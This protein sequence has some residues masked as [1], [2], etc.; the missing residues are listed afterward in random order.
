MTVDD[1]PTVTYGIDDLDYH[2]EITRRLLDVFDQYLIP[3]IGFVNER[4][5]YWENALDT[6]R[7]RLLEEW[8]Q[9]G[10]EL[11][12]HTYAHTNYHQVPLRVYAEDIQKGERVTRPLME[13]YGYELRYFRHPYLRIGLTKAHHDSLRQFLQQQQ[14]QEAPVTI[15]NDDYLFAKAYHHAFVRQDSSLMRQIGHD[16]VAY[17]EEKVHYFERASEQLEGRNVKHIL[18][19]H[20]NKLNADYLGALAAMYQKNQYRFISLAEALTD[21]A[22][23]QEI[24]EYDDW[25]IS[26]IDRWALS[27]GRTDFLREDPPTP[28]HIV[29]LA[30][31][32]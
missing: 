29:K 4:K 7:V 11:G 2:A 25:G 19:L 17:M 23:Q 12:N 24:T 13:R 31:L 15:D 8:L 27:R 5:L 3:A 20:A 16:Y 28:E 26:W 30:E 9:R 14:Y 1:L 10:Y 22:Y 18:L 21:E 6:A 32:E